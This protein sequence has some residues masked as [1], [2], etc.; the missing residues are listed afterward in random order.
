MALFTPPPAVKPPQTLSSFI[1]EDSKLELRML[2]PFAGF[3]K[4][5][6]TKAKRRT[7]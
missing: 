5:V 2:L 1:Q 4:R 3:S 6:V 7:V